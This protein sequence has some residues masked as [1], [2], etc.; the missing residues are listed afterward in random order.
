MAVSSNNIWG[1]NPVLVQSTCIFRHGLCLSTQ[2]QHIEAMNISFSRISLFAS[3]SLLFILSS[4]VAV[5]AQAQRNRDSDEEPI[6]IPEEDLNELLEWCVDGK[7]E[8]VLYKAIRYTEDDQQKKHP[9]PYFYMS[10]AYLAI[11]KS[12]D[13]DLREA[14][15]VEKLKALK[16]SLKYASKFVKKDR[17][18]DYVPT[19][20]EFI[21]ELRKETIVAAETEMDNGKYTKAKGYYKYLTALDEEDPGAWM[22]FGTVYLTLKARRDAEVCWKEAK[23]L[24]LNQQ[25]RGLTAGQNELLQYAFV[26]TIEQLNAAGDQESMR[27]FIALGEELLGND[28]E[29]QAVKRSVGG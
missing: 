21:E 10:K 13:A 7:H 15:E 5:E 29:F 26:V 16:N 11:H 19:E 1:S 9:M 2:T 12:D 18:K 6:L 22:M 8:K 17:D 4:G 23:N 24:L 27:E 28:R 14:Y 3:L 20:Q 25:G